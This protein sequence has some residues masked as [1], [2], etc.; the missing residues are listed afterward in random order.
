MMAAFG[1]RALQPVDRFTRAFDNDQT[2]TLFAG[3]AAHAMRPLSAA[4]S[5]GPGLMLL[6]PAPVT[7]WPIA[8][9]G[10]QAIADALASCFR[11]AGGHIETNCRITDFGQLP[12]ANQYYFDTS[13]RDL[14]AILGDHLPARAQRR[15][16]RWRYGPGVCKIDFLLAEPIPWRS[17][18]PTNTAT[19]HVAQDYRQIA[20]TEAA[21]TRGEH[22]RRPWLLAGEP[23]RI[24]PS[25]AG[26]SR[27]HVAWAYCHVPNGSSVD[28]GAAMIDELD[29]C[30]PGF[31]DVIV[32]SRVVTA[33]QLG[34]YDANFVG[35]DIG[36]GASS[37]RQ[38]L[39]RPQ[40]PVNPFAPNPYAT[41]MPGVY[42]CSSATAPGGGVH[43][44]SGYWAA[45]FGLSA[46]ASSRFRK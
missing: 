16:A 12:A 10:S 2:R 3:V 27:R 17:E 46:G 26:G 35:G 30:A 43:G 19:V 34:E 20:D 5:T 25:R 18:A 24:D 45:T 36:S 8:V 6:A 37:L 11:E 28:M 40:L 7:G 29:R 9:G 22:P 42:L 15:Y 39:A 1:M 41:G 44:M 21:V 38:I 23:T 31:R 4:A 32:D 14:V 33:A 13:V